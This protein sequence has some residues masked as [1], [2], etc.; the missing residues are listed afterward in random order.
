MGVDRPDFILLDACRGGDIAEKREYQIQEGMKLGCTHF[1]LLDADMIY[2]PSTIVDLFQLLQVHGADMA[3]GLC[4]RGYEPYDP[5]IWSP[6]NEKLLKPFDDYNFGD[7]VDA[8]ATGAACLLIKREVFEKLERPWFRIQ[9]E[10]K[11]VDGKIVV[12]RRGE[13]TF[14]TRNATKAGFKL[15]IN[16]AYDIGHLREFAV[17]RHFWITFGILNKMGSWDNAFKL[18]RKLGDKEWWEREFGVVNTPKGGSENG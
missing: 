3:G 8:G 13:D 15:L 1:I 6:T 16:T 17:D 2:P 10:E 4:Y 9:T 18:F 11:T 12:I 5:L 7:I 14:F